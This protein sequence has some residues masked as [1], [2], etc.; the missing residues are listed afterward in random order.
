MRV[1]V[2]PDSFG[3]TLSAQQAADAI[4][5]GWLQTCPND[6]VTSL[7]VCDGGP[8]FVDAIVQAL[9][10][11]RVPVIV[12]DPL[13]RAVPADFALLDHHAWIESAAACGLHLIDPS[14]RNVGGA[15]SFGLGQLIRAAIESGAT[16]ITIGVGG[17][18]TNDAGAGMLAALGAT[19]QSSAG[20]DALKAGGLGLRTFETINLDAVHALLRGITLEVATDVDNPLL[21]ARGATATYGPQKGADEDTVMRLEVALRHFRDLMGKRDD[22]KD[23][24]VALGAGSGGGI[25]YALLHLGATRVSGI[26]FVMDTVGFTQHL[27]HYD[28]VIT[29]EGCLDDQSLHGKVVIGVATKAAELGKPCIALAGEV[30]LGKRECAS[31]GIDAAYSLKDTFGTEQAIGDASASLEALAARVARTWGRA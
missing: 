29:G 6:D 12:T 30:R 7:P 16:H 22:G 23:A 19:G 8:G 27:T 26:S 31:A 10:A 13:G 24:S 4:A 5:R 25:G 28:L 18:A 11:S 21:G 17:T 20:D 15:S 14:E 2:S 1:L 9:G 3:G